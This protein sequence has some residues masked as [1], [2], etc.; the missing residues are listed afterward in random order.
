[1]LEPERG[2]A[3]HVRGLHR[4]PLGPQTSERFVHVD[5]V[6]E[7][8]EIDDNAERAELV[9]LP[10]PVALAELAAFAVE[11]DAGE[12]VTALAAVELVEDAAAVRFVAVLCSSRHQIRANDGIASSS[13]AAFG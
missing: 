9:L 11:N 4:M 5:R 3:R 12:L 2:Q 1:V 8:H 7:H 13:L 10:L 6:P